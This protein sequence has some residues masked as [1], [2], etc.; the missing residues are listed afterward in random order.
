MMQSADQDAR[1]TPLVSVYS[2]AADPNRLDTYRDAGVFRTVL[3]LPAAQRDTLM[4][5]ID[6]AYERVREHL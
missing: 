2:S 6:D 5:A 1:M 4:P 3:A